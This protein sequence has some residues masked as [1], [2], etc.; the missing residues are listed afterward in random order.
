[1]S[2]DSSCLSIL[3]LSTL[4]VYTVL[5]VYGLKRNDTPPCVMTPASR[6]SSSIVRGP[7]MLHLTMSARAVSGLKMLATA[8]AYFSVP[9]HPR[10]RCFAY[11]RSE[12]S[13]L[14]ELVHELRRNLVVTWLGAPLT[15]TVGSLKKQSGSKMPRSSL[16]DT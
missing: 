9:A 4:V 12:H 8:S 11:R 7:V 5:P 14:F 10:E 6:Q 13:K 16:P 1:M 3:P 2:H 15:L